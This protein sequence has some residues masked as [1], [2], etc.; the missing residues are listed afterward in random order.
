MKDYLN[1][2]QNND[3]SLVELDLF[4][5][6]IG[7][8]GAIA[9]SESLKFNTHL[10]HLNIVYNNIGENGPIVIKDALQYNYSLKEIIGVGD[11]LSKENR[12]MRARFANMKS[13]KKI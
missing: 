6:N 4:N 12:K 9:I 1:R 13:A 11:L 3:A 8:N 7:E 2:L 10:Q 5:N